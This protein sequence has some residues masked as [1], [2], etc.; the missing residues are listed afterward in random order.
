M[1]KNLELFTLIGAIVAIIVV[2]INTKETFWNIPSRT[3]KVEKVLGMEG[4][5]REGCTKQ[6]FFQTPNF[7]SILSPRFSNVNYGPNLRTRF[8]AYNFMGVPQDPLNKEETVYAPAIRG[9]Q[10]IPKGATHQYVQGIAPQYSAAQCAPT[11][12]VKEN[13][14]GVPVNPR[15]GSV[16]DYTNGNYREVADTLASCGSGPVPTDTLMESSTPFLTQDGEMKNP[17]V[18]DRYIYAN[19]NSRL[20]SQ[21]DPIRGDLPIVPQSGNWFTPSVHPNIDLRSGAMQV[22]GGIDNDTSKELANL[23]YNASGR[24]DTTIG[25]VDMAQV[26]ISNQKLG[27]LSAA[28]GDVHITAFP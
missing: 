4:K 15:M 9:P 23:I 21:G 7:Q 5:T 26:N 1:E 13:Y 20:R 18:Y 27:A 17:I 8:P 2:A 3:W 19:R 11:A 24:A 6:D 22:L 16:M 14:S 28:G 12:S 10:Y 25:G